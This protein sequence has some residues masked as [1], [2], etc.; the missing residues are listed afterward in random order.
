MSV[1]PPSDLGWLVTDFVR[2]VSG[3]AHAVVVSTDGL[4]LAK[5]AALPQD[6]ADQLCAVASSLMSLS[7]G[8]AQSFQGGAVNQTVIEM[9][10]GYLLMMAISD[11]STLAVLASPR[12]EI[13]TVAYE[14]TLLVERVGERL[15]P[16]P[17]NGPQGVRG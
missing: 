12:C 14:M 6:R 5:S 3:V 13:G 16:E 10:L 15:T 17:R 4:L 1:A 7:E 8:A 11:G 2:R 9:E